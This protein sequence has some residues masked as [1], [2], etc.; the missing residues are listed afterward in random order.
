MKV[1]LDTS[2]FLWWVSSGA[3]RLTPRARWAIQD[4]G[5]EPVLSAAS[6]WEIAIEHERGRISLPLAPERYVPDLVRRH[7]FSVLPVELRHALRAGALPAHHRD[8]FDRLLVAQAQ[9]EDLPLVSADPA[10]GQYESRCSGEAGR[11]ERSAVVTIL[12]A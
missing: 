12:P 7:G 1:L 5:N 2:A 10:I 8:P 9:I 11:R 6:A 3:E 4:P